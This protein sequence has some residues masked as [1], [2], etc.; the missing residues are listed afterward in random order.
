MFILYC[1][2]KY[3]FTVHFGT[4]NSTVCQIEVTEVFCVCFDHFLNFNIGSNIYKTK[5]QWICCVGLCV[6]V[7]LCVWSD[8]E[9][10]REREEIERTWNNCS[11]VGCLFLGQQDVFCVYK[12]NISQI[13]LHVLERF[14]AQI[15][16]TFS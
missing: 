5:S 1:R 3:V 2:N 9:R 16:T 4:T 7:C 6:C 11:F 10:E 15:V 8:R 12:L 14:S 13:P